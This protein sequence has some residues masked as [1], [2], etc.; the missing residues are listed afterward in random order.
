LVVFGFA[1]VFDFRSV[2]GHVK[3]K[4]ASPVSAAA[5]LS[6]DMTCARCGGEG[7]ALASRVSNMEV[8]MTL[9]IYPVALELVRRLSPHLAAMRTRSA[10]LGDQLERALIRGCP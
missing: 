6:L 4:P 9:E 7:A 10:S 2:L 8:F 1:R 3:A 5:A